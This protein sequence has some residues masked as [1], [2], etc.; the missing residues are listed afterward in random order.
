MTSRVAERALDP[1]DFL[2]ET[3]DPATGALVVVTGGRGGT[4]PEGEG[5]RAAGEDGGDSPHAGEDAGA[6]ALDRALGSIEEEALDRFDVRRCRLRVR[7]SAP[8]GASAVVAVVRAPHRAAAFE[9]A[10]WTVA[11]GLDRLPR[12]DGP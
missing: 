2:R 12:R 1:S 8:P 6:E 10:R 5:D 7:P 11:S 3:E 4:A 9:A